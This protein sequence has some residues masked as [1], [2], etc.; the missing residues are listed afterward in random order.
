[1]TTETTLKASELRIGNILLGYLTGKPV[2]V[3]W[4]VLKHMQDGNY[5]S[6][7]NPDTPVYQPIPLTPEIL[8]KAG[9]EKAFGGYQKSLGNRVN[10]TRLGYY[11]R[12]NEVYIEMTDDHYEI[13]A[14]TAKY[15]HQLQNLYFAL[16]GEELNIE[17]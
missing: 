9:F 15:L 4:V 8:E 17:L 11:E 16:T 5:R 6:V 13:P 10:A 14:A 12:T 2:I 7:Y 1:M 3:D